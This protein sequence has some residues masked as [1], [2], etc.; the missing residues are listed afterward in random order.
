M[1]LPDGIWD[2]VALDDQIHAE[3]RGIARIVAEYNTALTDAGLSVDHAFA[4]ARDWHLHYWQTI[5]ALDLDSASHDA[6]P[7]P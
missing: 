4:L 7:N 3:M 1:P 5:H 6:D 2:A